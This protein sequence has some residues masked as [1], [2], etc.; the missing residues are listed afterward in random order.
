[1]ATYSREDFE[2][3]ASAIDKDIA[4]V[5]QQEKHFEAAAMWYHLD[6]KAPKRQ[7]PFV[8]Q[9]R[10][11]QIVHAGCLNIYKSKISPKR[12]MV[13]G[14]LYY[15]FSRR[16]MMELRMQLSEQQHE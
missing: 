16:Q 14:S 8:I 4:D 2:E 13:Q 3:I 12:L 1:M 5:C 7:T 10:M 6:R 9:R 15:T 11:T